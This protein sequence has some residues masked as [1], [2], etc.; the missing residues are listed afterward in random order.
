MAYPQPLSQDE[1]DS[2]SATLFAEGGIFAVRPMTV[3][4]VAYERVFEKSAAS[5]R[6]LL[7]AKSAEFSDRPFLVYGDER[8]SFGEVWA[9]SM[10]FA[11]HLQTRYGIGPG[12]RVAIAMRNYPEW[13][14]AYFG[15]VASG[16]TVVP[17]NAWWGGDEM[18]DGLIRCGARLVV[19]DEKRAAALAPAKA[20]LD[21]TLIG[22][23]GEVPQA[24]ERLEDILNDHTLPGSPPPVAIAPD[25]DFCLLF[26]SGSTGQPK[27]VLLTHRSA[28]NAVLSWHFMANLAQRLRPDF[29]F[30]PEEPASLLA[31]PLFHVTAS[32]SIL[33]LSFLT[34]RK[35]VFMHK[36][37][38]R[39]AGRL[40]REERVTNFLG[41]PTMA[42]DLT[43]NAAPGDLETL[44]DMT[45]GGAKRP[46]IQMKEQAARFPEKAIASGYGLTETNGL[47]CHITM[48]DFLDRPSSTGRAIPPV[49][50]LEAFD[51]DGRQLR[52]GEVGEICVK[53]PATFRAYLDDEQA[54]TAAYFEGGWFRTGDLGYVDEA[55]Y[56]FIVD[57]KKDLIIRG[58][59]N[60]ACL[61][62]ENALLSF[63]DVFEASVFA[64]PDATYGETVGALIYG[65]DGELVSLRQLE[66]FMRAKLAPFKVPSHYWQSAEPLPRGT[67]GKIDKRAIRD[68]ARGREA[69]L[70]V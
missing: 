11:H 10:R 41:V 55:G 15:I 38:A 2:M 46:E 50:T 25:D 5:I 28:A 58:G 3:G 67:T 7:A 60:I 16:A 43:R 20:A 27:G 30:M 48:Q 42:H 17:L 68:W 34:G 14:M 8:T 62:V 64:V 63:P 54:T 32:H 52:R 47:G 59:E 45:T 39:E 23:R 22:V 65:V 44:I 69:D 56:L 53:S 29:T 26:T 35:I 9:R 12:Q 51:E 33:M 24:E 1:I 19:A 40:I 66:A 49:T 6:D 18:R 57:R 31:L 37:D 13:A 61:E 4:G 36:W 21:L 70:S